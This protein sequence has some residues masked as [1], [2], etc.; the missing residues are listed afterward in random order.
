MRS[1]SRRYSTGKWLR[2]GAPSRTVTRVM[3]LSRSISASSAVRSASMNEAGR[4]M[5][6]QCLVARREFLD[7]QG[8][9][10][11][12]V[13]GLRWHEFFQREAAVGGIGVIDAIERHEFGIHQRGARGVFAVVGQ[14]GPVAV[15][16][17]RRA[18]FEHA[19]ASPDHRA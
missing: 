17:F 13:L 6:G 5:S 1:P 19:Q 3:K 7:H 2:T 10:R 16:D 4:Y 15:E 12:V 11:V 14:G 18:G 8:A 9:Q